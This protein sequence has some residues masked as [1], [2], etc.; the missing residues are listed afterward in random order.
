MFWVIFI[1]GVAAVVVGGFIFKHALGSSEKGG[2]IGLIIVGVLM[3]PGAFMTPQGYLY[4]QKFT[5]TAGSG[6]WLVIDNS[7]GE[8]LRH[9]VLVE[10]YVA[11]SSQ[12]DGW[13]FYDSDG[14]LCYVSGD[15]YVMQIEDYEKFLIDYKKKYNIPLEQQA[16]E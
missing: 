4:W 16:L 7:G 11:S 13:Q 15:A 3:I 6:S 10:G 14:N 8:T 12:S 5:A 2:A 1:L 9:W